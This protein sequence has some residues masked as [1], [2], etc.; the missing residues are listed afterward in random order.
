MFYFFF[1]VFLGQPSRV[2]MDSSSNLIRSSSYESIHRSK[3]DDEGK[4]Q[5]KSRNKAWN[6]SFR[7]AVDKSY[8]QN[9]HDGMRKIII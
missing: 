6:D 1:P 2:L 9:N 3:D 5:L 8:G 4:H 7:Q